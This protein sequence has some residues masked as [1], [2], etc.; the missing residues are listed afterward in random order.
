M[1]RW[2]W[3]LYTAAPRGDRGNIDDVIP[4]FDLG[5]KGFTENQSA[6]C[7]DQIFNL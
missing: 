1:A 7:I 6:G 5:R 4:V 3:S 2:L